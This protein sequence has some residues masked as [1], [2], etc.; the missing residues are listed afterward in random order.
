MREEWYLEPVH[1]PPEADRACPSRSH[2]ASLG[3][4]TPLL[5]VRG[6]AAGRAARQLGRVAAEPVGLGRLLLQWEDCCCSGRT[7]AAE[8]GRA[9]AEPVG[10]G[11]LLL[12]WEHC[13]RICRTGRAAAEPGRAAAEPA[14]LG[15]LL[16]QWEHCCRIWEGC[17]RTEPV[18]GPAAASGHQVEE[19]GELKQAGWKVLQCSG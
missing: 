2:L 18:A 3:N 1:F 12:Q 16:L 4:R 14:G 9:A 5:T 19:A 10:L 13:C 7:A 11:G 6:L 17:C 15:G 8:P